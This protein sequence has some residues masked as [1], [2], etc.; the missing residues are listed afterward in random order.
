M[1]ALS[2]LAHGALSSPWPLIQARAI[3]DEDSRMRSF[4]ATLLV[5][6]STEDHET[7]VEL[8]RAL[9]EADSAERHRLLEAVA[10]NIPCDV[11]DG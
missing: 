9:S 6:A 4:A 8:L 11:E 7:R 2:T 5:N 10:T 3:S 1:L